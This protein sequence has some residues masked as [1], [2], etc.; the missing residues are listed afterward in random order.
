ME[1][2]GK[3]VGFL[4]NENLCLSFSL[5][6]FQFIGSVTISLQYNALL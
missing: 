6:V 1:K 2:L 5:I 3:I 4:T